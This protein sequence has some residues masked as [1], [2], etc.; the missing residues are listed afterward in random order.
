MGVLARAPPCSSDRLSQSGPKKVDISCYARSLVV[1]PV[2]RFGD[3]L[4]AKVGYVI[5]VRLASSGAEV[6]R[7]LAQMTRWAP[8]LGLSAARL[9]FAKARTD[10]R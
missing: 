2:R 10:D 5:R 6:C 7:L 3:A 4:D 9:A 8:R 1:S